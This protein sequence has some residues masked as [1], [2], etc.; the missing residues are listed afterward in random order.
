MD[1]DNNFITPDDLVE[2][3]NEVSNAVSH[4]NGWTATSERLPDTG[5]IVLLTVM[6]GE[7]RTVKKGFYYIRQSQWCLLDENENGRR[8]LPGEEVIAWQENAQTPLPINQPYKRK[9]RKYENCSLDNFNNRMGD[10]RSLLRRLSLANRI[11]CLCRDSR[12]G[13]VECSKAS[14]DYYRLL[15]HSVIATRLLADLLGIREKR[16]VRFMS[17]EKCANC[18]HDWKDMGRFYQCTRCKQELT[19]MNGYND[20]PAVTPAVDEAKCATCG[21]R[22]ES[23]GL[24]GGAVFCTAGNC[25]CA[26]Y[27]SPEPDTHP[28]PLSRSRATIPP[29]CRPMLCEI[30]RIESLRKSILATTRGTVPPSVGRSNCP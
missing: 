5:R 14:T 26:V 4:G 11:E 7:V 6:C 1:A 27:R 17:S 20:C 3:V 28:Y 10:N 16:K 9:E 21:H 25:Y 2:A 30:C 19:E 24:A 22:K 23:H 12:E 18:G 15:V 13:A 29:T 8:L